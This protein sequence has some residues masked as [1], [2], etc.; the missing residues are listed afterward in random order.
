M[1]YGI[2]GKLLLWVKHFLIGRKFYVKLN[3]CFSKF[4]NV[5]SSVPQGNKL[6]PLLYIIYANDIADLFKFA[7][8]KMYADDL[9]TYACII[10]EMGRVKFQNEL[11]LNIFYN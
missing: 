1:L 2:S 4:Y 8:I 6:D 5:T 9:T 7:K 10:N 11:G 3:N